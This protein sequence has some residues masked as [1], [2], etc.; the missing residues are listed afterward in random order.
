MPKP[1]KKSDI[2]TELQ[3]EPMS[4][5]WHKLRS[6]MGRQIH[7][8]DHNTRLH[9]WGY[10]PLAGASLIIFSLIKF[11]YALVPF[12]L[13]DPAWELQTLATFGELAATLFFGAALFFFVPPGDIKLSK[14]TTFHYASRLTLVMGI[15]CLLLIP[16][17]AFDSQRVLNNLNT[18]FTQAWNEREEQWV[19]FRESV[20]RAQTLQQ[21]Y[22]L[23]QAMGLGDKL[24]FAIQ[25]GLAPENRK[26]W[27]L[28]RAREQFNAGQNKAG[29]FNHQEKWKLLKLTFRATTALLASGVFFIFLFIKTRWI[30]LLYLQE[31]YLPPEADRFAQ[32]KDAELQT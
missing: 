15:F 25:N 11:A 29:S 1:D 24:Q 31:R 12:R 23:A 26:Q 22:N 3:S 21:E 18:G 2:P 4:W 14:L 27:I 30:R 16:L 28:A 9:L 6:R 10:L 7:L 20:D 8:D 32:S 17:V 19:Q 13:M 5:R